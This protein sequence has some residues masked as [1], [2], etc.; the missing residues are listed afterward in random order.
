MNT[1]RLLVEAVELQYI[2][3]GSILPSLLAL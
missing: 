3:H 1:K 2:Q